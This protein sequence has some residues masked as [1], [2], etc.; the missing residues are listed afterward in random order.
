MYHDVTMQCLWEST[1]R[2]TSALVFSYTRSPKR[3]IPIQNEWDDWFC[4]NEPLESDIQELGVSQ[5]GLGMWTM[6]L[7]IA[8]IKETCKGR[9]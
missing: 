2:Y 7:V 9:P 6:E 3:T 5:L 4:L 8:Q 1:P